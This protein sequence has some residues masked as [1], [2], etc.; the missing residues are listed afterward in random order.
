MYPQAVILCLTAI[1][2]LSFT[3]T[4]AF[5]TILLVDDQDPS[6]VYSP[7]SSWDMIAGGQLDQGGTH[8]LTQDTTATATIICSCEYISPRGTAG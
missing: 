1:L 8:M 2:V 6:I 4:Y 7:R 3:S 5:A